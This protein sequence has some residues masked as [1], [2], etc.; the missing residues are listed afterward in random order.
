MRVLIIE[1]DHKIADAIKRGLAAQHYSVDIANNGDDGEYYAK[2]S[3]YDL[4]ILDIMLPEKDGWEILASIRAEHI[5]TPVLMLTALDSTEHKIRGLDEG[6]DDYMTKPFHIGELL[7]RVRSLVR[8]MSEHKTTSIVLGDL[9][10]N[11]ST[12]EVERAGNPI[13]L[14]A[15]EFALLE[16]F[17]MNVNKVL[18]REMIAEH[19]WDMNFDPQ[20]NVIDSFVRF[21]R[22]KIDKGFDKSLIHTLRGVGYKFNM[23]Q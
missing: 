14:S 4:I 15:K 23:E 16:Y 1:D 12:R 18:T 3:D 9:T 22:Q 8:R 11:T 20:S 5:T 13:N 10:I 21:L 7:A 19:V 6:A 17:V 2:I